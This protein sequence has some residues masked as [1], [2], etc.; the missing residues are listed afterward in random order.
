M[1]EFV[2]SIIRKSALR[3]QRWREF[4]LKPASVK[5]G[6]RT[7]HPETMVVFAL[8]LVSVPNSRF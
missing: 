6:K 8:A 5:S 2:H 7:K 4:E 3:Q 1:R